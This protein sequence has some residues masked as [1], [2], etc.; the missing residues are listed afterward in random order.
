VSL[1]RP[2]DQLTNTEWLEWLALMIACFKR[3]HT[4]N[5]ENQFEKNVLCMDYDT[6]S[7]MSVLPRG[8][9]SG[10]EY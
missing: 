4:S 8:C 5:H 7:L 2:K 9:W 6:W 10:G 1:T 3:K